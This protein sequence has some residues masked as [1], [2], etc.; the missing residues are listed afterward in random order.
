MSPVRSFVD[1][2][3]SVRGFLAAFVGS[4][5]WFIWAETQQT[6]GSCY[7]HLHYAASATVAF[8]VVISTTALSRRPWRARH[9]LSLLVGE[10]VATAAWTSI[11]LLIAIFIAAATSC[12]A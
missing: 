11:G 4:L 1:G 7:D 3:R 6:G 12:S 10:G 5:A 8:C 2:L 9:P